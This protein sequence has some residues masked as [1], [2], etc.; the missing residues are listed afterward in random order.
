MMLPGH[1]L[2]LAAILSSLSRRS[3]QTALNCGMMMQSMTCQHAGT[4]HSTF[5][6]NCE[7]GS[8]AHTHIGHQVLS[9]KGVPAMQGQQTAWQLSGAKSR[10]GHAEAG[11]GVLG[12]LHVLEQFQRAQVN[13]M[14]HLRTMNPHVASVLS[15]Q[16]AGSSPAA[17]RQ[18]GPLHAASMDADCSMGVSSFAFQ[19]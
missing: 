13:P 17:P 16:A 2:Y 3:I 14:T 4:N 5:Q 6:V 19:V 12:L 7:D 10:L 8:A 18:A 15:S 11:A 9:L 1:L